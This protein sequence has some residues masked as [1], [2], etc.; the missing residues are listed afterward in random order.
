MGFDRLEQAE[1]VIFEGERRIA[2]QRDMI[3]AFKRGRRLR[4][5]RAM[6]RAAQE[7]LQTLEL[8][9]QFNIASRNRLSAEL[10]KSK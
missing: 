3:A 5:H 1:K 2:R 8:A 6:L 10:A 4:R 7:L 9:Q